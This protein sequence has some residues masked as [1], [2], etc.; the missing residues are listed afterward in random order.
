M[1]KLVILGFITLHMALGDIHIDSKKALEA[2]MQKDQ[3]KA[4]ELFEK[5]CERGEMYG[6]KIL[7]DM[8]CKGEGVENDYLKAAALYE[9]TC[10]GGEAYGCKVLGDMYYK[11]EGVEKDYLKAI[12]FIEKA[13]NNGLKRECEMLRDIQNN[14]FPPIFY[15]KYALFGAKMDCDTMSR[16]ID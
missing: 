12:Q 13:C 6:C 2:Y 7:G 11:G 15:N 10:N 4:L 1:K 14:P 16:G 5:A 8:Y 9:K 3:P